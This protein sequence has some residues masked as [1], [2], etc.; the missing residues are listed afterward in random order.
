MTQQEHQLMIAM[1]AQQLQVSMMILEILES[2]N[3]LE[4][5]DLAAFSSFP[6]VPSVSLFRVAASY[7]QLAQQWGVGDL[8]EMPPHP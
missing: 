6:Q 7:R 8:P 3:V 1:L 2:K 4:G 5:D